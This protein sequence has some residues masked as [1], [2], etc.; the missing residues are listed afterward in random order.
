[1]DFTSSL[2]L[3]MRH[4]SA[5]LPGWA[6]LTTGRP[7]IL[8]RTGAAARVSALL[9]A[10]QG[11]D[12]AVLVRSSLHAFADCLP[13]LT[14]R[15]SGLVV[16]AATYPIG[17]WATQR[18]AGLGVPV[19]SVDHQDLRDLTRAI[20]CL[21]ARGLRPVVVADGVCGGCA[22]PY[23]VG[24]AVDLIT[25]Q[26]G[27]LVVDDTQA[28]GLFGEP[29]AGRPFGTGG[30]GSLRRAGVPFGRVVAIASLAKAFGAPAASVAG[31]AP[32][33]RQ[34]ER[35]GGSAAHSSPPSTVDIAAAARAL[36]RNAAHGDRLRGRLAHRIRTL[37]LR[38]AERGLH[39]AGGLFPVQATPAVHTETGRRLL[40]RLSTL[41]VQAVLR[42]D[43]GGDTSAVVIITAAHRTADVERAADVLAAAWRSTHRPAQPT[44]TPAPI[45]RRRH[46]HAQH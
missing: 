32:I 11:A 38:C 46:Q 12:R 1:M 15:G 14:G 6:A 40:T 29:A 13:L 9:A 16:D 10:V 24:A 44:T 45:S 18:S 30:G 17:R 3:G 34:I 23:P 22:R 8:G 25:A 43:C 7:A 19:T 37:R 33:I 2:Y 41:G 42:R 39:L 35:H 36:E 21:A 20:D 31:P 5:E 26:G 4:A 27:I 28:I